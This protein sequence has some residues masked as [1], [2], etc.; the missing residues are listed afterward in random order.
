MRAALKAPVEWCSHT[1]VT[2][3]DS[4]THPTDD[5][6]DQIRRALELGPFGSA[7]PV[8]Q[9][10]SDHQEQQGADAEPGWSAT[11]VAGMLAGIRYPAQ[12]WEIV[13]WAQY[14]GAS[15]RTIEALLNIAES[16][17][18]GPHRIA[19]AVRSAMTADCGCRHRRH[20]R[21]CALHHSRR[22]E[23]HQRPA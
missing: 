11:Q 20:P 4:S 2:V 16:A 6:A 1:E 10:R 17:Y 3:F 19:E 5:P 21:H 23:A 9:E 15:P 7:P 18:A 12:R 22:Q 13:A 14:N 8:R